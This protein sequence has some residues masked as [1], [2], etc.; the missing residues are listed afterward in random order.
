MKYHDKF[1]KKTFPTGHSMPTHPDFRTF[2]GSCQGFSWKNNN[3]MW[4]LPFNSW[5]LYSNYFFTYG[6][7]E[8]WLSELNSCDYLY[9]KERQ[10]ECNVGLK[11]EKVELQAERQRRDHTINN[12]P[13]L[14]DSLTIILKKCCL[15]LLWKLVP[16]KSLTSLIY[17]T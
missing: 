2:P 1:C 15:F 13:H 4:K 11:T 9:K 14:R 5:E 10:T 3:N 6:L 17:Q 16:Q 7:M 12:K 8:I